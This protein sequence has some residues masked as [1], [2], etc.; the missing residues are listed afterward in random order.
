MSALAAPIGLAGLHEAV[1]V[2]VPDR[3]D[4]REAILACQRGEKGA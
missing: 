3:E 2:T 4:D 1:R